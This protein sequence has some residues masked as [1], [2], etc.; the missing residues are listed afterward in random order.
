VALVVGAPIRGSWWSHPSGQAIYHVMGELAH[1]PEVTHVKLLSGKVTLVHRRLWPHLVALGT[2]REAWQLAGLAP[3]I[4]SLLD[5]VTR[6][7]PVRTDDPSVA[8]MVA[9][10]KPAAAALELERRLL[11]VGR[12]V[13]TE[14]GAHA[15]VLDS[16]DAWAR[17]QRLT[18][19]VAPANARA[20]LDRLVA[21]LNTKYRGSARLPWWRGGSPD[22]G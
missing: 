4:R 17:R 7:P 2:A 22:H 11:V 1:H 18:Q 10:L 12:S 5:R 16:W 14:T 13:H 20:E 6:T 9:P 19:R 3:R 21:A 8:R 15:K